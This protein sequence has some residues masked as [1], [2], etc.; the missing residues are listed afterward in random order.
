MRHYLRTPKSSKQVSSSFK[1]MKK[2]HP[3]FGN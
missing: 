2:V 3:N 1:A